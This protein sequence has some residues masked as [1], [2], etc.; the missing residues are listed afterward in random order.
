M[1][2]ELLSVSY[3]P[4]CLAPFLSVSSGLALLQATA[5]YLNRD[6]AESLLEASC[7][8]N[9]SVLK[10]DS[11]GGSLVTLAADANLEN[12]IP[13]PT[14]SRLV[15]L[16]P[17]VGV[18]F[19]AL[20]ALHRAT[21]RAVGGGTCSKTNPV[22]KL[23]RG[24]HGAFCRAVIDVARV[25]T[26]RSCYS[27][28][29]A[30]IVLDDRNCEIECHVCGERR[31]RPPIDWLGSKPDW[32]RLNILPADFGVQWHCDPSPSAAEARR[33]QAIAKHPGIAA[34]CATVIDSPH[35]HRT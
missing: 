11:Y 7:V 25:K 32:D 13:L 14:K 1:L 23:R 3:G 31:R 9:W 16:E 19:L 34:L 15:A 33:R 24:C 35:E 20:P 29:T 18:L 22:V 28:K 2:C 6:V 21:C 26:C 27:L 8:R 12:I 10:V 5:L 17:L 4:R 30:I